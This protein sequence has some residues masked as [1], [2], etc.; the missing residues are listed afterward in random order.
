MQMPGHKSLSEQ[1][2][3][4][5]KPAVLISKQYFPVRIWLRFCISKTPRSKDPTPSYFPTPSVQVGQA[6]TSP[7][8]A[9]ECAPVGMM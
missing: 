2:L 1:Q 9:H 6:E 7:S 8:C 5:L 3:S 4:R